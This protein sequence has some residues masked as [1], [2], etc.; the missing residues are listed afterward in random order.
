MKNFVFY[1]LSGLALSLLG[2]VIPEGDV[3][4]IVNLL[5]VIVV[6]VILMINAVKALKLQS[7]TKAMM[8]EV[9]DQNMLR[10][11]SYLKRYAGFSGWFIVL[12]N[13]LPVVFYSLAIFLPVLGIGDPITV[14]TSIIGFGLMAILILGCQILYIIASIYGFIAVFRAMARRK[15]LRAMM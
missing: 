6:V 3:G 8:S 2:M 4:S 11:F 12:I 13:V 14:I 9:K 7:E 1:A 15:E 5:A 10:Y